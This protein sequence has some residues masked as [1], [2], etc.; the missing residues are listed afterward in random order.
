[1][2]RRKILGING[3]QLSSEIDRKTLPSNLRKNATHCTYANCILPQKTSNT[4]SIQQID[5]LF[6]LIF[7]NGTYSEVSRNFLCFFGVGRGGQE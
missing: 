6:H 4:V 5:S 7:V 3:L 2:Q 1:M